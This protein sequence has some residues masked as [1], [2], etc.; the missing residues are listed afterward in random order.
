MGWAA[1][2]SRWRL[3]RASEL[4]RKQPA[5]TGW[6]LR[7]RGDGTGRNENGSE[8]TWVSW[9]VTWPEWGRRGGQAQ[10]LEGGPPALPTV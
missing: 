9:V 7:A 1:L 5:E 3:G 8:C 10:V 4:T 6:W 2:W